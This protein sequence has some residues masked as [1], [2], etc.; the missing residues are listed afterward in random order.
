M[1]KPVVFVGDVALDE[2]YQAPYWPKIKDKVDV[3]TLPAQYGGMIAN[4]C[5]VYNHLAS[6]NTRFMG[7]LNRGAV[8]Q[9]LIQNLNDQGIDTS[10]MLYDD[11]LPDSKC[12]IF[13]AEG[14]HTIFIPEMPPVKMEISDSTLKELSEAS[15]IYTTINTML[16]ASC[17]DLKGLA[18]AKYLRSQGV[19]LVYDLDVDYLKADND[20]AYK[21]S[22][23]IFVNQTGRDSLAHGRSEQQL[24]KD[25]LSYGAKLFV[26]TLAEQGVHIYSQNQMIHVP[27]LSV[28]VKDVTGAGDTFCASFLYALQKGYDPKEAGE[29]ATA[30]A[31][32][33]IQSLG[34]RVQNLNEKAVLKLLAQTALQ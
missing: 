5:C 13:L 28:E 14:E 15:Y 11:A 8:S 9:M 23:I 4:A 31:A 24:A 20:E 22:D 33:C 12:L 2:Y 18:L 10:L 30:A 17:G 6:G 19:K 1:K 32:L 25:F 29:F 21:Q 34:A 3:V 16:S 7:L 27:A 26:V